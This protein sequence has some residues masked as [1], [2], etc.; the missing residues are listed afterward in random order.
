MRHHDMQPPP[1]VLDSGLRD[2]APDLSARD[3]HLALDLANVGIWQWDLQTDLVAIDA[4]SRRA[5]GVESCNLRW[6]QLVRFLHPGDRQALHDA[7]QGVAGGRF[8]SIDITFRV[9]DPF[10]GWTPL[11]CR[12]QRIASADYGGHAQVLGIF[13]RLGA[14]ALASA[15]P[16][17]ED[18]GAWHWD[19]QEGTICRSAGW[20]R[21]FGYEAE[22]TPHDLE[23][24]LSFIHPDDRSRFVDPVVA[25]ALAARHPHN[26]RYQLEYRV[27]TRDGSYVW[28]L[29][30][31]RVRHR[32]LSGR[33]TALS[34][35]VVTID[36][37]VETR[38]ALRQLSRTDGLT[39]IANRRFFDERLAELLP[40]HRN[41]G[42]SLSILLIDVD[43]FKRYN[44]FYGH[45]AGDECLRRLAGLMSGVLREPDLIARYGGEE[46]VVLLPDCDAAEARAIADRICEA[47]RQMMLVHAARRD[48]LK[49]VTVSIGA[50]TSSVSLGAEE[51]A[52]AL[53]SAADR[54]LY[55]AKRSGRNCCV[56]AG[57][58]SAPPSGPAAPQPRP[59]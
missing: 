51:N 57:R 6:S 49:L 25:K 15:A 39:G 46:F 58:D 35:L 55:Q 53:I 2:A 8:S 13:S 31:V 30:L 37:Q 21:L 10:L 32:D 34:G 36:E 12:G 50:A 3:L 56:S 4:L 24:W 59:R 47:V 43:F 48:R 26:D 17:P 23:G 20:G 1:R 45:L 7:C 27:R 38:E 52:H 41:A 11:R 22:K 40:L 29:D 19:V 54:G 18:A 42:R 33:A 14:A 16:E 9:A 28:V 5:I 44:D